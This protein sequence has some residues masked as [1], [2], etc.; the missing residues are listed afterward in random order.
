LLCSV[1]SSRAESDRERPVVGLH[2][3]FFYDG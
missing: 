1:G 2:P 3:A